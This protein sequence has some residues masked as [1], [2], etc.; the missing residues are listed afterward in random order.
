M[1]R[2]FGML[3]AATAILAGVV[4]AIASASTGL[5]E[6]GALIA[7]GSK[8]KLTNL[9]NMVTTTTKVGNLECEEVIMEAELK[10]NTA[11]A[12]VEVGLPSLGIAANKG[13]E[14]T[15][16]GFTNL[17]ST[18]AEAGT[19]TMTFDYKIDTVGGV[20]CTF[21]ANA[22]PFTYAANTDTIQFA[23]AA[24]IAAPAACGKATL[25]AKFTVSTPNNIALS[26]M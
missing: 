22:A 21:T 8:V 12:G 23:K 19:G 14:I 3:L 6:A 24:L 1:I 20:A 2:K 9:G 25:D 7:V 13:C 10:K 5:T 11:V 26:I 15:E 4:P 17:T 16:I 18:A